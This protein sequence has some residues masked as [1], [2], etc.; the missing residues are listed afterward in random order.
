MKACHRGRTSCRVRARS[1]WSL[2]LNSLFTR[3]TQ[4]CARGFLTPAGRDTM[5]YPEAS[6]HLYE[7]V[8]VTR[9]GFIAFRQLS[10]PGLKQWMTVRKH[11]Q[12]LHSYEYVSNFNFTICLKSGILALSFYGFLWNWNFIYDRHIRDVCFTWCVILELYQC[13]FPQYSYIQDMQY[14]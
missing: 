5:N 2:G 9:K 10:Q 8:I 13:K 12:C 1:S 3:R 4:T 14:M 11:I 7:H 6:V